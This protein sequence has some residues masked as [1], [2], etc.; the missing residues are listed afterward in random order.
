M[1]MEKL[2]KIQKTLL[3]PLVIAIVALSG[4]VNNFDFTVDLSITPVPVV[5]GAIYQILIYLTTSGTN[6]PAYVVAAMKHL[7]FGA[8]EQGAAQNIFP[9]LANTIVQPGVLTCIYGETDIANWDADPDW[10]IS[11]EIAVQDSGG[12][13]LYKTKVV[14]F[15][16]V[17]PPPP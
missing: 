3:V 13:I 14:P 7:Y 4:C 8:M 2:M 15:V 16:V 1:E 10:S 9:N 6:Q 11:V 5:R 17:E 12:N